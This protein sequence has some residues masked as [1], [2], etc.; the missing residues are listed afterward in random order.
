MRLASI[1]FPLNVSARIYRRMR[2]GFFLG[3]RGPPW[4]L[5]D[6]PY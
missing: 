4:P 6:P 2:A 3:F 5:H 1:C